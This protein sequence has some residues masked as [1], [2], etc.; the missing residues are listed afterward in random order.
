[1]PLAIEVMMIM[2]IMTGGEEELIEENEDAF[3]KETEGFNKL[4]N[5]EQKL[6]EQLKSSYL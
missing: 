2:M 3:K 1:M 4:L 6:R 5:T